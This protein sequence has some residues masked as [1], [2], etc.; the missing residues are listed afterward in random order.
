MCRERMFAILA[1]DHCDKILAEKFASL[2]ISNKLLLYARTAD[3]VDLGQNNVILMKGLAE[4]GKAWYDYCRAGSPR[5]FYEQID[6]A[7]WFNRGVLRKRKERNN[8]K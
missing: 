6:Y 2:P 4:S 5:R 3:T 8:E 1:V 7:E